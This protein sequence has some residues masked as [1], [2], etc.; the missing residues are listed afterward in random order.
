MAV[1]FLYQIIYDIGMIIYDV[2]MDVNI[3]WVLLK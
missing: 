1:I 3:C 2:Y